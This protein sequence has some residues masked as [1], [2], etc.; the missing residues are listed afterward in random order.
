MP[1]HRLNR[2]PPFEQLAQLGGEITSPRAVN[3]HCRGVI[4]LSAKAFI[5]KR[6]LRPHAGEAFHLGEGR[7]ERGPVIRVAGFR[8]DPHNPALA[9]GGDDSHFAAK[10][11]VLL[12]FALSETLHLR[13][14]HTIDLAVIGPL[15]GKDALGHVPH[16]GVFRRQLSTLPLDIAQHPPQLRAQFARLT[17]GPLELARRTLPS[18]AHQRALAQPQVALA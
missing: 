7:L 6:F 2:R 5:D 3:G 12:P 13:G 15:W 16:L 14:M 17:P 1:D 10:L 18:L 8:I 11:V 4:P 9:R